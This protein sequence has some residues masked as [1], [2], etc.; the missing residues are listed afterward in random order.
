MAQLQHLFTRCCGLR[1]VEA[2]PR[3]MPESCVPPHISPGSACLWPSSN[4]KERWSWGWDVYQALQL[5]A[6][7]YVAWIQ[8]DDSTVVAEEETPWR[9][10][11]WVLWRIW[12]LGQ[13]HIGCLG[14]SQGWVLGSTALVPAHSERC[15][16]GSCDLTALF[17]TVCEKGGWKKPSEE[18]R[19]QAKCPS[20]PWPTLPKPR[21][22]L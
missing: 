19:C 22:S 10:Q 1:E 11:K 16:T 20:F 2:Q 21:Y 17:R 12:E 8:T 7:S 9:A 18:Q 5:H 15:E 6:W 13:V 4:H 14:D 3:L